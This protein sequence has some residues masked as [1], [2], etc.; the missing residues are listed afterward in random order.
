MHHGIYLISLERGA[1]I[2]VLKYD[3]E[4]HTR[5]SLN[6]ITPLNDTQNKSVKWFKNLIQVVFM[7]LEK[8]FL[9]LI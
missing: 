3:K 2:H 5:F 6:K 8:T 9:A 4:I 7:E 1:R